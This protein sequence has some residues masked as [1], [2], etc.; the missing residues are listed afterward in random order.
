MMLVPSL[1]LIIKTAQ[2]GAVPAYITENNYCVGGESE[3][4]DP[5]DKPADCNQGTIFTTTVAGMCIAWTA[6]LI[7]TCLQ[8]YNRFLGYPDVWIGP[9][10]NEK[11]NLTE[12]TRL[13]LVVA[14][15]SVIGYLFTNIQVANVLISCGS[16]LNEGLTLEGDS[17]TTEPQWQCNAA[18]GISPIVLKPNECDAY[19]SVNLGPGKPND[20]L[21]GQ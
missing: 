16:S 8:A 20:C 4:T 1:M 14:K 12:N 6:F 17:S 18:T 3:L 11:N 10:S 7:Q 21:P 5:Y 9:T 15:Y 13:M 2:D 19:Q